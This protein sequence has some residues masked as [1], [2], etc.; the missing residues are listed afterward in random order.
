MKGMIIMKNKK[1]VLFFLIVLAGIIVFNIFMSKDDDANMSE[2]SIVFQ[3]DGEKKVSVDI[4]IQGDEGILYIGNVICM[5][6]KPTLMDVINTINENDQ[7]VVIDIGD[8]GVIEKINDT[9]N[10]ES[11]K[12]EIDN[13]KIDETNV[14]KIYLKSMQGITIR[15]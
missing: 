10:N 14:N 1:I 13:E 12:I 6:S 3:G 7:G 5:D 2:D 11:W 4:A 15:S 8:D 9:E